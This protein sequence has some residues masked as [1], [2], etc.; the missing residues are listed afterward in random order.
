MRNFSVH[1][2]DYYYTVEKKLR[3]FNYNPTFD[4]A[5]NVDQTLI[6]YHQIPFTMEPVKMKEFGA[7]HFRTTGRIHEIFNKR[8]AK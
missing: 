6:L 5:V 7:R 2:H 4:D 3:V 1:G 8:D